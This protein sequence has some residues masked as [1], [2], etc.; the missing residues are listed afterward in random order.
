ML[1]FIKWFIVVVP[2]SIIIFLTGY[3]LLL[4]IYEAYGF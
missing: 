3:L 2:I 4:Y 1:D